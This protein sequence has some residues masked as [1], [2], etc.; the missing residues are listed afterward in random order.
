MI[1][2]KGKEYEEIPC[3]EENVCDGCCF[4]DGHCDL[5]GEGSEAPLCYNYE[6]RQHYIFKEVR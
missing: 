4:Y 3:D 5:L 1:K 6:K 2:Y